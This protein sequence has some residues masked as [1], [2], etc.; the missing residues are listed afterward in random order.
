MKPPAEMAVHAADLA[1][2]KGGQRRN[3]EGASRLDHVEVAG[4][5]NALGASANMTTGEGRYRH[6]GGREGVGGTHPRQDP[7]SR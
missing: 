4:A 3:M 6:G 2:G 1:R 5:S 7:I